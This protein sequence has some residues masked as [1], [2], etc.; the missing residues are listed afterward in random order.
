MA[1]LRS[2]D[3]TGDKL[4]CLGMTLGVSYSLYLWPKWGDGY[5]RE[6]SWSLMKAREWKEWAGNER[7]LRWSWVASAMGFIVLDYAICTLLYLC[8][9]DKHAILNMDQTVF[10]SGADLTLFLLCLLTSTP[11]NLWLFLLAIPS[12]LSPK[13]NKLILYTS[14]MSF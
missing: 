3:R 9:T 10:F 8:L 11:P 4:L 14:N 13:P 6:C 7:V 5:E 1:S 2:S 12:F